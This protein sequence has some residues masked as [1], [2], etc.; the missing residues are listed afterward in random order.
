MSWYQGMMSA[1]LGTESLRAIASPR[2]WQATERE[3]NAIV[4]IRA[5]FIVF[6]CRGGAM[7]PESERVQL[8]V[9]VGEVTHLPYHALCLLSDH[10][11][12]G[13]LGVETTG[14]EPH[15]LQAHRS[16]KLTCLL[17]TSDAA[18]DLLCV[19]LGGRR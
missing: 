19:D 4:P 7:R 14:A 2:C 8:G 3:K 9:G 11:E 18:D 6:W 17:Y 10:G 15:Q 1:A 12:A 16:E 13:R 5:V